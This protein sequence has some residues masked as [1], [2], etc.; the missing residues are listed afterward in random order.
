MI[1]LRFVTTNNDGVCGVYYSVLHKSISKKSKGVHVFYQ[2]KKKKK[3]VHVFNLDLNIL[4]HITHTI[5]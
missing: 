2:K 1:K 4:L 3:G 5:M